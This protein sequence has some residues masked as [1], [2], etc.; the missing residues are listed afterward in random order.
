MIS[1][2]KFYLFDRTMLHIIILA[3]GSGTRMFSKIP[4]V[5]HKIAGTPMLKHVVNTASLMHP[6]KIHIVVKPNSQDIIENFNNPL[7]NWDIQEKQ[8]GTAHAVQQALPN[9]PRDSQV[10][11]LYADVPLINEETI[12]QLISKM[13]DSD[14][15]LLIAKLDSP[16]G[17]G[18][19]MR[20]NDN[21]IQAIVEEKDLTP[22]QKMIQE[23]YTGACCISSN[24]L[25]DL[26]PLI[27]NQ[28]AQNEYYLT[29]I[30]ALAAEKRLSISS[31]TASNNDDILG[32]NNRAQLETV[33]RIF[34]KRLANA[35]MIKGVTIA[36]SNRIDIR[37]TLNCGTDVYIDI[38]NVFIDAVS[39]GD[40][41]II[42]PNCMLTNV[43]I[44]NNSIIKANSVL[45]N[46]TIA[47]DCQ[48]GPFARIRPGTEISNKCAIGNFVEVKNTK[49]AENSKANH[50]SYLGDAIIGKNVNIGAGTITCNYD[51]AYKHQTII[52][53]GVFI[54]SDTQLVAPVTIGSN[55]TI[56]AGSTIR[57]D[58]PKN[59]LTLTTSVQK[60]IAGWERPKK[61]DK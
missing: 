16:F 2:S 32:V 45:E 61:N 18:R 1:L 11:I 34:Q 41:S 58:A 21:A 55:A 13:K 44:G 23:T 6:Q 29:D 37:G 33:E 47:D 48:I 14:L 10:L 49:I 20:N 28:N 54:G 50:L 36:D 7:I 8:L 3:A 56:G 4:K 31:V 17:F 51:G 59:E 39:I 53:D 15:C 52:E 12:K 42:E 38:N 9:I 35:L 25:H 27:K 43:K 40:N 57:E 60:T 46:C 5:M 24:V 26:L 30:I 19:I 22:T